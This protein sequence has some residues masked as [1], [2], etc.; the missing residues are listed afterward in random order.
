MKLDPQQ[1]DG[2]QSRGRNN[3]RALLG[4]ALGDQNILMKILCV[5]LFYVTTFQPS[6][7]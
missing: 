6:D 4:V 2:K 1:C 3:L 5:M 7:F